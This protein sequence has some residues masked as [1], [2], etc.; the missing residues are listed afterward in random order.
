MVKSHDAATLVDF[1]RQGA[2]AYTWRS[3]ILSG[4]LVSVSPPPLPT[5]LTSFNCVN[6]KAVWESEE[7]ENCWIVAG[8]AR[9]GRRILW[10]AQTH[11]ELVAPESHLVPM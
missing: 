1:R 8:T 5:R 7:L 6:G 10:H 4:S 3:R 11:R 9:D 2:R